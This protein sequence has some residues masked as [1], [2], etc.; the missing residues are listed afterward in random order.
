MPEKEFYIA[1]LI[2]ASIRGEATA[3]EEKELNAWVAESVQ[4]RDHFEQWRNE[5]LLAHKIRD[6]YQADSEA[7][8][9][10]M[11]KAI[12]GADT[13]GPAVRA[14]KIRPLWPRIAVA[15][16]I[17]LAV[18]IAGYFLSHKPNEENNTAGHLQPDISPGGNKAFLVLGNG[19][20]ISLTDAANGAI[21]EQG[22]R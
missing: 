13:A 17:I 19:Q 8:Y 7:I 21:A 5:G 22:G 14:K 11:N 15:A 10:K 20:R 4:N 9:Q 6:Y 3:D 1:R 2:A 16:S 12:R 18:A